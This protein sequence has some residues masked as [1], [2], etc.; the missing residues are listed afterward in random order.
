[1]EDTG[2][3]IPP[4]VLPRIFERFWQVDTSS[5][6]KFQGRG[7]RPGAR[8]QPHGSHGWLVKVDSRSAMA[9]RSPSNFPRNQAAIHPDPRM[10]IRNPL[11]DGGNIAQLHR[12][13][14]MSIPGK[15]APRPPSLPRPARRLP[16][17]IGR[18]SGARPLVLI[19]DDEPDIRRFLSMQMENVDVIEA[20][21][22]AEA[23]ELAASGARNSPCS[24]T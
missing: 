5:T 18:P 7:H 24:T 20:C 15:I 1:V 16:L 2:V 14:A 22:G 10:R 19:A 21:D 13:A 3:G 12:K 4:E 9:R 6:R 8:P 23:L 17:V 11:P